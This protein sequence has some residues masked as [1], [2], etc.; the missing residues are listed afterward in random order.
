MAAPPDSIPTTDPA[1][2]RIVGAIAIV[3]LSIIAAIG[4][5]A[6]DRMTHAQVERNAQEW[7]VERLDVLVPKE[8]RDN[9]VLTDRALAVAPDLLGIARPVAVYRARKGGQPVAAILHTTAPDGYRGPIELLVAIDVSGRLIGV[10]V[11]RHRETPGLGDAFENRNRDW[12]PK[13]SGRSLDDP[14]QQRWAVRRDGGDFDGFT[15][16]TITPRAIVKAVRRS[17]EFYRAK[18][19]TIFSAPNEAEIR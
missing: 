4:L 7:L 13:F 2:R 14:P 15:G 11:V 1:R 18:Q 10:Q 6:I 5:A 17:L 9:D 19:R 3:V 12:L 8:R 16:A